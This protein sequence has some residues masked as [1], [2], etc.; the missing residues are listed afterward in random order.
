MMLITGMRL[1]M[2]MDIVVV[3]VSSTIAI[4]NHCT[5][6]S[7]LTST[8]WLQ[9]FVQVCYMMI[10]YKIRSLADAIQDGAGLWKTSR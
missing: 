1:A 9:G 4:V 8:S 10:G 6:R 7:N 2:F 3:T 5:S